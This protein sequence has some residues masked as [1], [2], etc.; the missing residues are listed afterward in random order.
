MPRNSNKPKGGGDC[1]N[2]GLCV[3]I[4]EGQRSEA[5]LR[6]YKRVLATRVQQVMD[7]RQP[8]GLRD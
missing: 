4:G 1:S 8:M 7:Y 3:G 5:A 2:R 6:A